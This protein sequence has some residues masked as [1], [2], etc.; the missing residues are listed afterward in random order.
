MNKLVVIM[1]ALSLIVAACAMEEQV[2]E[3]MLEAPQE[4]LPQEE[5]GEEQA[6][7]EETGQEEVPQ[8]ETAQSEAE[9]VFRLT[10]DHFNF[11]DEEGNVAPTLRVSEGALV[12]IEYESTQGNHDWV[13]DEFG[14]ATDIVGPND[15][16]TVVEFV[17][18][19]SGEFEYYCSVGSHRANG[20]VGLLVVE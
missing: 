14:A 13:V 17:A 3:T 9:Y 12:R 10:G 4:E 8:E 18:D 19:Q 1:I 2:E 15:G 7:Q 11:Y 5:A 20:M 6:N 16:V